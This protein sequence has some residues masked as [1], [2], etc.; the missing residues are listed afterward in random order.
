MPDSVQSIN[1]CLDI[2]CFRRENIY[3]SQGNSQYF[4]AIA[5]QVYDSK[6]IFINISHEEE[7]ILEEMGF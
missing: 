3:V 5:D 7:K 1:Y 6:D 2:R 4:S